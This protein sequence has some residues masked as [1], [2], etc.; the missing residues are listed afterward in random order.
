M[1][2]SN[3]ARIN[4][5]LAQIVTEKLELLPEVFNEEKPVSIDFAIDFGID[6]RQRLLK[7][8]FKNTFIQ[9]ESPFITIV[10]GCIFAID[11]ASWSL[12]C[13]KDNTRFILPSNFAGYLATLTAGTAR[14]ILHGK[15]EN[16]PLNRFVIPVHNLE[17]IIKDNIELQ[18]EPV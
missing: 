9:E 1:P 2:E 16:T 17:E 15:S 12:F 10:A 5:A 8:L 18:L 4:F 11:P 6:S 14:G 7:V 3:I 13:S